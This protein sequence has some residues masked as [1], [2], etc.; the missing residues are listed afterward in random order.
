MA[1]INKFILVPI[2]LPGMGKTTLS[3]FL[4]VTSK[5]AFKV[6]FS[7]KLNEKL[8][9]NQQNSTNIRLDFQKIS[10][11]RILTGNATQYCEAHPEAGMHEAIDIIRDKAD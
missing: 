9:L 5:G 4:N 11:D 2:G 6:N 1:S 7:G 3:R 10:Y 8:G